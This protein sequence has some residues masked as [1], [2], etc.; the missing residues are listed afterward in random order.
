MG[1]IVVGFNKKG[2]AKFDIKTDNDS[3]I[4]TALLGIESFIA[5]KS[6]LPVSEIRS[7][8]DEMKLD[9]KVKDTS[10]LMRQKAQ[11]QDE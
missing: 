7:I 10:E 2:Q 1:K 4:F 6:K 3:Q 8:M 9:M 5:A 11:V